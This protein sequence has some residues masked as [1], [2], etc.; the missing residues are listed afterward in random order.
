[1][2]SLLLGGRSQA[3][4]VLD[5]TTSHEVQEHERDTPWARSWPCLMVDSVVAPKHK[6]PEDHV[7]LLHIWLL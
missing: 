2:P 7:F 3:A 4:E 1:M 6:F 5:E